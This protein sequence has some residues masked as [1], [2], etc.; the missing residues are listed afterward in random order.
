MGVPGASIPWVKT[1][2]FDYGEVAA[3][4]KLYPFIAG[5]SEAAT[6]YS[7]SA[8]TTKNANP[9]VLDSAGRASVFFDRTKAVKFVLVPA[10][11]TADPPE[12][13]LWTQDGIVSIPY[14]AVNLSV[15][16]VAPQIQWGLNAPADTIQTLDAPDRPVI[17]Y[18]RYLN[19]ATG[20]GDITIPAGTLDPIIATV[21]DGLVLE[22]EVDYASATL[23]ARS[24]AFGTA[25]DAGTGAASTATR[26][27]YVFYRVSNTDVHVSTTV[28]QNTGGGAVQIGMGQQTIGSLNLTTT[29]YTVDMKMASGTYTI[30]G[31]R[32]YFGKSFG[33]WQAR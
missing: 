6:T 13:P 15:T 18:N 25:V 21:G 12:S 20:T 8:L 28:W 29:D 4:Y 32:A 33:D 17:L 27:Q 30:R 24:E 23:S 31:A 10:L 1:Q 14:Y 7:D 26:A 19:N 5:T 16:R 22:W 3:S 11:E 9:I 2:F